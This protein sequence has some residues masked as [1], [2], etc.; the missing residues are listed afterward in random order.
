ME[1][2]DMEFTDLFTSLANSPTFITTS[3]LSWDVTAFS[4]TRE[5]NLMEFITL[6]T[7]SIYSIH[8][9]LDPGLKVEIQKILQLNE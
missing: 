2:S 6:T 5:I 8:T 4:N 9:S 7:F 1:L 3:F